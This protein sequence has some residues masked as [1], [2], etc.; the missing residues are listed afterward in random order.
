M[1]DSCVQIPQFPHDHIDIPC[2]DIIDV[3]HD[4][5]Y[6]QDTEIL[7]TQLQNSPSSDC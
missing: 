3:N 2:A 7:T 4:H 6:D 1:D 5:E